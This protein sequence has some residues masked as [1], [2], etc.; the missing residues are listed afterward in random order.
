[1]LKKKAR[2]GKERLPARAPGLPLG[3]PLIEQGTLLGSENI[4]ELGALL[5]A[6]RLKLRAE[7][8][9]LRFHVA[10]AR[11][12]GPRQRTELLALGTDVGEELRIR[13]IGGL[14][15]LLELRLLRVGEIQLLSDGAAQSLAAAEAARLP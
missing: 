8:F 10:R 2:E 9:K 4:E 13:L 12:I 11:I 3:L 7:R 14:A 5:L 6:R 15:E 1:L